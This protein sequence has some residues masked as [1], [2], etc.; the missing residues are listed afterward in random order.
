[1]ELEL[2]LNLNPVACQLMAFELWLFL[3][4]S[5]STEQ[6]KCTKL[7]SP[8]IAAF[9]CYNASLSEIAQLLSPKDW[10]N[11]CIFC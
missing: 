1:M 9:F 2:L 5:N 10:S 8:Q 3:N 4:F 11:L 6:H 7:F